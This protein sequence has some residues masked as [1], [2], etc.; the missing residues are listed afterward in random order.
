MQE[1]RI[2]TALCVTSQRQKP[3]L[4]GTRCPGD[5]PLLAARLCPVEV[6]ACL[7]LPFVLVVPLSTA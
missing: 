7:P 3:P 5:A 2:L 6:G 1:G 4:G